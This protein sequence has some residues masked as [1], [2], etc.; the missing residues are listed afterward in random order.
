MHETHENV[1][2]E[3]P[4]LAPDK[5]FGPGD[6]PITTDYRDVLGEV[7]GK[8]LKNPGVSEIFPNYT[9]WKNLGIVQ[10]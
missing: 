2:C 6:L 7:V 1:Q 10:G 3:W 8:R 5:L 9:D 4:G